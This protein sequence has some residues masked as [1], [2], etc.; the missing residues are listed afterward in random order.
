MG[1]WQEAQADG[2]LIM[3]KPHA[4]YILSASRIS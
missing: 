4:G 3:N 1:D 2:M